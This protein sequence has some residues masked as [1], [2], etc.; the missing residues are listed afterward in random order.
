MLEYLHLNQYRE[1]GRIEA[2]KAT[3][4]LPHS[5]WETYSAFANTLGGYILL[6]VIE[7]EDKSLEA[8][9]LPDPQ[10]LIREFNE[11]VNNPKKV[12]ANIL[13]AGDV[14]EETADGNHIV[15]IHV[16]KADRTLLPVYLDG[17]PANAY[18]RYG[19]QDIRCSV[20][21]Y[22]RMAREREVKTPDMALYE[23]RDL[24]DLKEK[25]VKAFRN[26][27]REVSPGHLT[28]ALD[29]EAFL[30]KTGCA[31][32]GPDGRIH[33]T[34]AGLLM[35]GKSWVIR[36]LFPGFS[37]HYT[38]DSVR[39]GKRR[40]PKTATWYSQYP[41]EWV[42]CENVWEFYEATENAVLADFPLLERTEEERK[43]IQAA[44]L[45]ALVNLLVNT[46]YHAAAGGWIIKGSRSFI[47]FNR[48]FFRTEVSA[49][50]RGVSDPRNAVMKRLFDLVDREHGAGGLAEIYLTW[51]EAGWAVPEIREEAHPD[52]TKV[53][54]PLH[55]AETRA[56][57]DRDYVRELADDLIVYYLTDHGSA[58]VKEMAEYLL[59]SESTVRRRLNKLTKE[60]ITGLVP[61]EKGFAGK[62]LY[63][64]ER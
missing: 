17:D 58:S 60:G 52:S 18:R 34:G 11:M 59:L 24:S 13:S 28:E 33:P 37:L 14:F 43:K 32:A 45:E 5:I 35:F 15:V 10:A 54:L 22:E 51:K 40:E 12:S 48:G 64:L 30:I 42:P 1:N 47:F 36:E 31:A 23:S 25:T 6:G 56:K 2:K 19:E 53:I 3:G 44:V 29:D 8:V 20:S 57:G 21:D 38:D 50:R 9:D 62:Q 7:K 16:P 46:D 26:R 4:G 63:R 27:M 55:P 39:G 49:A 41:P 61:K